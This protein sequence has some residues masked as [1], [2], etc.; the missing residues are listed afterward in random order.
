MPGRVA[1][2]AKWAG[3]V[4]PEHVNARACPT[5]NPPDKPPRRWPPRWALAFPAKFARPGP[6]PPRG[7]AKGRASAWFGRGEALRARGRRRPGDPLR[8]AHGEGGAGKPGAQIPSPARDGECRAPPRRSRGALPRPPESC[9]PTRSR[10]WSGRRP[11]IRDST[12]KPTPCPRPTIEDLDPHGIVLVLDQITD[13][14]NVGAILRTAAALR[15]A[16]VVT[17]ARHSPEA[18]GVLANPPPARSNM[19]RSSPCRISPAR[20]SAER[21]RLPAGRARQRGRDRPRRVAPLRAPLALVLGAEGK[22]L[23]QLTR[24]TCDRVAR[25]D[26]PGR[27]KSLNVSNATALALY[28][29]TGRLAAAQ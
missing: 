11:C 7:P 20:S 3:A 19:C 24:T 22:G 4:L 21:A 12:P 18:T 14:H 6:E 5:A 8:L 25:L 10:R 1:S 16:A 15:V 17:T 13:P 26:L 27:I 2:A 28:I 29:A 23:R 9:G